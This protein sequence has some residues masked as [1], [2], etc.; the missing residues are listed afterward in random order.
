MPVLWEL[1]PAK[2]F[3]GKNS[4]AATV[5]TLDSDYD[6]YVD[7]IYA[8]DTGGSV[9]RVDMPDTTK[10]N[11]THFEFAKLSGVTNALD[12]RFFYKPMIARTMFSVSGFPHSEIPDSSGFYYLIFKK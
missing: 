6:G 12:R 1:T 8:A 9:W 5:T 4:I 7:R 10:S 2:G 3:K 11:W